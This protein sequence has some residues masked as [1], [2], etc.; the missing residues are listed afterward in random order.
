MMRRWHEHVLSSFATMAQPAVTCGNEKAIWFTPEVFPGTLGVILEA[1]LR[2]FT[3]HNS[4][5]LIQGDGVVAAVTEAR[6][7]ST[8]WCGPAICQQRSAA[9]AQEKRFYAE[10]E[11]V[12][13]G[14]KRYLTLTDHLGSVRDVID[15]TG[16]PTLVGSFDYRPY[17]AVARSWGTVTTGYTYAGLFAQTNT[18]LIISTTRAYNPANGKW[19]NVDPIR[20]AGGINLYGYVGGALLME[21]DTTGLAT[22]TC[23]KPLYSLGGGGQRSGPDI[24]FNPLYH[25]FICVIDASGNVTCGGQDHPGKKWYDPISSPGQPTKDVF[26]PELCEKVEPDNSCLEKCL[27][28]KFNEPRPRYGIPFGQDCHEWANGAMSDCRSQCKKP[29]E[30]RSEKP[31][32]KPIQDPT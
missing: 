23:K 20:E 31:I 14:A 29:A 6:G 5:Y 3:N 11:Y 15:I 22:Y 10:G 7:T 26:K 30:E 25:M 16:T 18:S 19:L 17:G 13:T 1:C 9:D 8:L 4:R 28:T 27:L 12:H 32:V 2:T 24:P 21:T